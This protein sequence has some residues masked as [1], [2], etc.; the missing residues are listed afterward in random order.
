VLC[1]KSPILT[2]PPALVPAGVTPSEF[3]RDL[4]HQKHEVPGLT[5]SVICVIL[6]L[7]VSVEHR[8]VTDTQTDRQ[9]D[10]HTTTAYT[11]IASRGKN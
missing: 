11:A 6:L 5:C 10:R 2:Y 3:C 1:R 7:A 8:L 9:T 4:R